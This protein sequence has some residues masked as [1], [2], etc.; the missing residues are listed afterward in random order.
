MLC[1]CGH[2]ESGFAYWPGDGAQMTLRH[3]DGGANNFFADGHARFV[4]Y[5][6]VL[7]HGEY[8]GPDIAYP[9]MTPGFGP[10]EE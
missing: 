9:G 2:D 6:E 1:Q 8:W 3:L 10:Y 7:E 5:D 4:N